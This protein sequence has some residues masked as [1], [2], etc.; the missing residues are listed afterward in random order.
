MTSCT[1]GSG[2]IKIGSLPF[3]SCSALTDIVVDAGNK[4]YDSR[5]NCNA[6]IETESN[7]LIQGS[8]STSIIPEG[9][10]SIAE[11][12]FKGLKGLKSITIPAV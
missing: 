3:Y 12:A 11:S 1:I 6:L 2:V 8:N 10:T 4:V 5:N 7:I 9:V